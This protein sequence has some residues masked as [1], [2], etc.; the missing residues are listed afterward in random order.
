MLLSII[1]WASDYW[2]GFRVRPIGSREVI[3]DSFRDGALRLP[4]H[5]AICLLFLP[6]VIAAG[7]D[8]AGKVVDG[9]LV[10]LPSYFAMRMVCVSAIIVIPSLWPTH[11]LRQQIAV[12]LFSLPAAY[13]C[14]F[15]FIGIVAFSATHLLESQVI[16]YSVALTVLVSAVRIRNEETAASKV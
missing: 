6:P 16:L 14:L 15:A 2:S 4:W 1:V 3:V 8:V 5:G 13:A 11:T 10:L 7:G 9:W 12:T